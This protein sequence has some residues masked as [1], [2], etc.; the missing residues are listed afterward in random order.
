[1][2]TTSHYTATAKIFH[3]LTFVMIVGLIT[4]GFYMADLP[5]SPD[6]I[7]LYN[8]HK[9]AGVTVFWLTCLRLLYR[10]PLAC[11]AT[12]DPPPALPASLSRVNQLA[13]HAGHF[14][15]YVLL[16]AIPLS[17]WL[18]SSA[19]GFQTV[20][21]GALPIPNLLEKNIELGKQLSELHEILAISMLVL[22][23]AHAGAALK[24]HFV[25]KNDVL[26]RM[27]P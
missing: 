12:P 7:K 11:A 23:V 21:L 1:M 22:L 5:T 27:L 19:K 16:F 14:G 25:E 18:M 6:K 3:W 26:R 2:K 15:L 20:Y 10:C 8:Y 4:L 9:W 24:H 17:G 13:A